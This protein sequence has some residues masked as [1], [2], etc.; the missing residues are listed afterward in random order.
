LCPKAPLNCPPYEQDV[1]TAI[2]TELHAVFLG[3]AL[4][5]GLAAVL[6]VSLLR[7]GQRRPVAAAS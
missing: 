5:A 1:T 2:V 6:A 3:A 7:G 4:S